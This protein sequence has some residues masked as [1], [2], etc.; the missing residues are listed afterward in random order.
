M[1]SNNNNKNNTVIQNSFEWR[2][3]S[4][5]FGGRHVDAQITPGESGPEWSIRVATRSRQRQEC[6]LSKDLSTH[7]LIKYKVTA[8][9]YVDIYCCTSSACFSA[10]FGCWKSF[11]ID[12]VKSAE[13][14]SLDDVSDV[15]DGV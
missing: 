13:E 3:I 7:N 5:G 6:N 4:L 12:G 15:G 11:P 2:Y 1:S 14:N 8:T 9:F 10:K